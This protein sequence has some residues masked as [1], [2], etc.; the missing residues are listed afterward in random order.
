M[1]SNDKLYRERQGLGQSVHG[2]P[3]GNRRTDIE[4]DGNRI[5]PET[6]PKPRP[7]VKTRHSRLRR[8]REIPALFGGGKDDE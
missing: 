1:M 2:E 3:D 6:P 5:A 4:P 7:Q 8:E